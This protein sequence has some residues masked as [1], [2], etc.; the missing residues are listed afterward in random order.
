MRSRYPFGDGRRRLLALNTGPITKAGTIK[1]KGITGLRVRVGE[2]T[3]F[4][5]PPGV[6]EESVSIDTMR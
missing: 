2:L 1:G 6:I 5:S 3:A 4:A